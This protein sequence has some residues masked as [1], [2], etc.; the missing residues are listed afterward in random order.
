MGSAFRVNTTTKNVQGASNI[1]ELENGGFVITWSSREQDG[2]GWGAYAQIYDKGG[3]KIGNEFLV[4]TTTN[5]SQSNFSMPP[6]VSPLNHGGFVISWDDYTKDADG[7]R[8]IYAQIFD[9]MGNAIAQGVNPPV[10]SNAIPNQTIAEDNTL[11]FQFHQM[12]SQMSM[13]LVH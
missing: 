13:D 9:A 8:G 7:S 3:N 6:V 5:G 1:S 2:S 4:N 12:P 11:N 10:L